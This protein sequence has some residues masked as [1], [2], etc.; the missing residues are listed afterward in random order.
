M[1]KFIE[2]MNQSRKIL[3]DSLEYIVSMMN[4]N[5]SQWFGNLIF[6]MYMA[7]AQFSTLM[8]QYTNDGKKIEK[9]VFDKLIHRKSKRGK[10]VAKK[11]SSEGKIKI[12]KSTWQFKEIL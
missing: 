9:S 12:L 10:N 2:T 5:C 8:Y 6:T 11:G 3:E 4:K 7:N 1:K